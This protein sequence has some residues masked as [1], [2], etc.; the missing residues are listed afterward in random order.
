[1][2]SKG[3]KLVSKKKIVNKAAKSAA[4]KVSGPKVNIAIVAG[5]FNDFISKGLLN[6]CLMELQHAGLTD[7]QITTV[8]V[9]GS[10][11]MPLVALKLAQKKNID[12][13]ICLGAVIRGDTYHFE[14]VAN[15]CA[16]GIMEASLTSGKPVIMGVLTTDTISQAQQRAQ[17][18]GGENK[19]RDAAR[20]VLQMVGL[21]KAIK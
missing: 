6:A 10:F 20:A 5:S 17:D 9:P 4:L 18:K 16:R 15:E 2:V 12:A 13:V 8:W 7:K 14:V 11:E 3:N 19:G 1:V 21:L